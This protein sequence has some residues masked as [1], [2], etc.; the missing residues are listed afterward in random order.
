MANSDSSL[1]LHPLPRYYGLAEEKTSKGK[2]YWL[3]FMLLLRIQLQRQVTVNWELFIWS[4]LAN[5][6]AGVL[7]AFSYFQLDNETLDDVKITQQLFFILRSMRTCF[8]LYS[9]ANRLDWE[10]DELLKGGRATR[11]EWGGGGR[12]IVSKFLV[13]LLFRMISSWPM[14]FIIYPISSLRPGADHFMVFSL[15]LTWQS[16]TN[17]AIAIGVHAVWWP[18]P[19]MVQFWLWFWLIMGFL[20][21]GT[22][23]N[24]RLV[25]WILRWMAFLVPSFLA[26]QMM[27]Q[28]QFEGY[29]YRDVESHRIITMSAYDIIDKWGAFGIL[30]GLCILH[31]AIAIMAIKIRARRMS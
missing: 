27:G 11:V 15:S 16:M 5:T 25:T 23:R 9:P 20:F 30:L 18:Y 26:S 13:A 28:N 10:R 19:H 4:A 12:V 21:S 17:T 22:L 8:Q 31:L 7:L 3:V 6:L 29:D 1:S 2:S 14:Y 24:L